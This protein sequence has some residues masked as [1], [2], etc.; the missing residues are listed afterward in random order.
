ME[1]EKSEAKYKKEEAVRSAKTGITRNDKIFYIV[2]I[3]IMILICL[4]KFIYHPVTVVGESMEPTYQNGDILLTRNHFRE[5]DLTYGSVVVFRLEDKKQS[6]IKRIEGMPGDVIVIKD[7]IFYR[8]GEPVEEGYEK[9]ED[10]GYLAIEM[11]LGK[12]Q[13]FV[14]GD[15]RND[16]KDSRAFGPI[17]MK[18]MKYLVRRKLF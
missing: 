14:L 15:N 8:N 16:S 11:I 7:G 3:A 17:T 13:Y 9:I 6:Y 4:I 12:G 5:S 1:E 2:I 18:E 10:P